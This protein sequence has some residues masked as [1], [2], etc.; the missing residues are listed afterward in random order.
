[1]AI[2]IYNTYIY[3]CHVYLHTICIHWEYPYMGDAEAGT[4][5]NRSSMYEHFDGSPV[6][7]CQCIVS[8]DYV[9]SALPTPSTID[10]HQHIPPETAL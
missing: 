4:A 8:D 3:I 1:M 6:T 9:T 7:S 5:F 2:C 10:Q